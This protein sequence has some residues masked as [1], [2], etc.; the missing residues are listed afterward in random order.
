MQFPSRYALLV[1]GPLSMWS[2]GCSAVTT[3]PVAHAGAQVSNADR[4]LSMAQVYEQKGQLEQAHKLYC[5]VLQENP[6]NAVAREHATDLMAAISRMHSGKDPASQTQVASAQPSKS[7]LT[8][9]S[10][11]P[12]PTDPALLGKDGRKILSDEEVA[13]R[14][15]KPR[16]MAKAA[17]ARRQA[18]ATVVTHQEAKAQPVTVAEQLDEQ[19]VASP[20]ITL[21]QP[22]T[23]LPAAEPVE[24]P[25]VEP[26]PIESQT[27]E[28]PAQIVISSEMATPALPVIT[29]NKTS[30]V[31]EAAPATIVV[32]S[33]PASTWVKTPAAR[34][35]PNAPVSLRGHLASLESADPEARKA[36]L[37]ELVDCGRDAITCL[38][39]I[40]AC[41]SDADPL[42]QGHAAW[43]LWCITGQSSE[44]IHSLNAILSGNQE[45]AIVFACYVLGTMGP[46]AGEAKPMLARLQND[47]ST[48]IRVHAAEAMLKISSDCDLSVRVLSASLNS[49]R[50][51]ERSLAAVALGSA[52]G[53]QRQAAISALITALYD[54]DASVRC[55]AALALGGYGGEAK[56]AV[57]ALEVA[58]SATD[59]ET[60]DAA[61]TALACIKK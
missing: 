53:T 26:L 6:N 48:A 1:V 10:V 56:N 3:R 34:L 19:P 38:P 57:S 44:S 47:D 27:I 20:T 59:N 2:V 17:P 25:P 12:A 18:Q 28:P 49:H 14:I 22:I 35:C 13:A 23:V 31:V 40:R 39:A 52:A 7:G 55:S 16:Q 32:E 46:Q 30:T 33:A 9:A 60:R 15:P 42:V 50:S 29:S 37:E 54:S 61:R 5:Q 43:A 58:A 8:I 21:T 51:E 11:A 36:G 41:L 4:L 45:E 24:L